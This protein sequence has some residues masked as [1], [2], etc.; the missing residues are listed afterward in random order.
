MVLRFRVVL[1]LRQLG[2]FSLFVLPSLVPCASA[3]ALPW[4][5]EV[6]YDAVGSDNGSSFVEIFGSAGSSLDGLVIEGINGADGSVGPTLELSGSIPV[7]GLWVVA[8]DAGDGTTSVPGADRLLNFDFQNGPDSIVLRS[9]GTILDALGY[10]SFA[11]GE[12]F[13]GEGS[14]APDVPAGSSLARR[15]ANVDHDDNALDFVALDTPTPGSAALRVVPEP[16]SVLLALIGVAGLIRWGRVGSAR[17]GASLSHRRRD[18]GSPSCRRPASR[19]AARTGTP[20]PGGR[21]SATSS[22]RLSRKSPLASS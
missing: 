14:P 21:Y 7:D 15:F 9:G 11:M 17:R 12:V 1:S 20:P 8:D 19:C 18:V 4:I 3:R 22:S 6:F 5:S 10:G 16:A 13:A 2:V